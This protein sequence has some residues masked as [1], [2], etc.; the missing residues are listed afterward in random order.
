MATLTDTLWL[1]CADRED[2]SEGLAAWGSKVN[3]KTKHT[4][5]TSLVIL[6]DS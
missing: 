1:T 6:V 2:P 4:Q 5:K 3:L